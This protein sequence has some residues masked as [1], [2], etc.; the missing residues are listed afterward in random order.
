MIVDGWI[1]IRQLWNG[2]TPL[3]V[4]LKYAL[5]RFILIFVVQST[6]SDKSNGQT[7]TF[8]STFHQVM[9]N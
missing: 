5:Q 6:M 3:G 2:A 7:H 9:S 1:V 8:L 4:R